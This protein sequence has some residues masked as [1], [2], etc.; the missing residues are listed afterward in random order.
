MIFGYGE[1]KCIFLYLIKHPGICVDLA[2]VNEKNGSL[3]RVAHLSR[4]AAVYGVKKRKK[5]KSS[6]RP[7]YRADDLSIPEYYCNRTR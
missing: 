3:G 2:Y 5:K 1:E 7:A 6:P 4:S